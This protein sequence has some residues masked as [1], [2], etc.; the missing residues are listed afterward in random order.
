MIKRLALSLFAMAL[1]AAGV[2][3]QVVDPGPS[4]SPGT[5]WWAVIPTAPPGTNT[6]QA[7][8]TA[9]VKNAIPQVVTSIA[10]V[11]T[12]VWYP[13][14]FGITGSTSD[15]VTKLNRACFG[16]ACV[17]SSD[18]TAPNNQPTTPSW[19]D[20]LLGEGVTSVSQEASLSAIG[21]LAITGG[22]RCSD[23]RTIFGSSSGGCQGG[24]FYGVNDDPTGAAISCGV[25][26]NAVLVS[27]APGNAVNQFDVLSAH[28]TVP[29]EPINGVVGGQ[30]FNIFTPGAVAALGT[31]NAPA[32]FIVGP[33]LTTKH[34]VGGAFAWNALDTSVGAGGAGVAYEFYCGQSLRWRTSV[35]ATANEIWT[36]CSGVVHIGADT[37]IDSFGDI[38]TANI[39][40]TNILT[41]TTH[42]L[43]SS[44]APT[45]GPCGGGTPSIPLNNGTASYRVSVGSATSTCVVNMPTASNGWNCHADDITTT[46][47]T[48]FYTKQTGSSVSSVT[49]GN[50]NDVATAANWATSDVLSVICFAL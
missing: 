49:F 35:P 37:T 13:T 28:T 41:N 40:P 21:G 22:S 4:P 38:F 5:P 18:I 43:S 20:T 42:L 17:A 46:S 11:P 27:A 1:T 26:G 29:F 50:F 30:A 16:P 2:C 24:T 10:G 9:F 14:Y 48:V 12:T 32:A 19:L 8:S 15:T 34:R 23:F 47:T 31:H 25:C 3:A 44:T 39:A 6:N 45:I 36:D 33:G 7:A